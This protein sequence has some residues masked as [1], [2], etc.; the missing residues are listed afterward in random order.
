MEQ[1]GTGLFVFGEGGVD[2]RGL[3]TALS[4]GGSEAYLREVQI[5]LRNPKQSLSLCV[6]VCV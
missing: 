2:M 3:Q 1:R 6:C 5:H 4:W